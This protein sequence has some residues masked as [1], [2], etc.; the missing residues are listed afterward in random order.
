MAVIDRETETTLETTRD[1]YGRTVHHH[2]AAAARAR[3]NAAAAEAY[4]TYLAPHATHLLDAARSTLD[5][6]PPARNTT[7]WR[8]LLDALAASHTEII[9]VLGRPAASGS[10]AEREQ[11]TLVWPHLA[12]WADHST[13][14]SD[15]ADQHHQPEPGLTGEEAQKWTQLAQAA[16]QRGE[17]DLIESWYIAD[18]RRITLAYLVEEDTSSTVVALAGDPDAPG[19]QVIGHY[20]HEYAAGQALPRP[21]PPGVLRPDIS[22]FNRPEPAPEVPVQELL[23]DIAEARAAGDVSE[24]LLTAT[25]RG[26]DAGPMV[27]L[28]DLLHRASHFAGALETV[29]G[30]Q[31]A[32]RLDAL[33]RQLDFLT[34]EVQNAAEDLGATVAVLPPHRIPTPPRIRPRPALDT[35]PPPPPPRATTP[36]HHP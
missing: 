11:H 26:H 20:A 7:A 3:R 13:I 17:L 22:H 9:R 21:V 28:Q 16:Q 19:W 24:T 10:A 2:A 15:L 32:A 4:A 1:R 36:A 29:Q 27:R 6:L 14:A 25:Q 23:Q 30:R 34:R 5:N 8:T 18:G 35:T 33:G 31:I 12:A